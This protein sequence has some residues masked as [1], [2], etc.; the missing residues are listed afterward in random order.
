MKRL[1]SNLGTLTAAL[2]AVTMLVPAFA[3]EP[4]LPPEQHFGAVGYVSGGVGELQAKAFEKQMGK[5]NLTIEVLERAG[6]RDE[7]TANS[8]VKIMDRLGH[9]LL[10]TKAAG[11]FVLVDL[12]AGKYSVE[13][14][15]AG[16]TVKR[17]GIQIGAGHH[18]VA[19]LE[20]P[21]ATD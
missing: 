15:L 20:F 3:A 13:A 11:P 18:A 14:D 5:F 8:E 21:A 17:S 12:P 10:D 9:E 1:F 4:S 16:R 6:R 19:K 7:F 2:G